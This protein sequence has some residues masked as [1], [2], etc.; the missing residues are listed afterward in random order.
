MLNLVMPARQPGDR[1]GGDGSR[2]AV[3]SLAGRAGVEDRAWFRDLLELQA[4]RSPDRIVIDLS[5]LSSMDWWAALML[6]W[7]ARVIARRGGL[8][9]LA[10]PRPPV[11]KVLS[12]AGARQV[13]PVVGSL[14]QAAHLAADRHDTG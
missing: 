13:I 5:G 2:L 3:V 12:S 1:A 7:V 11:A 4:A 9:V 8:L 10:A 14:Q 6:L